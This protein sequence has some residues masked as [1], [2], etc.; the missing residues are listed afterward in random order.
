MAR[1][2]THRTPPVVLFSVA[3][4]AFIGIAVMVFMFSKKPVKAPIINTNTTTTN[5]TFTTNATT[6]MTITTQHTSTYVS[7]VP[8]SGVT[9]Q[10][11]PINVA[12]V[13]SS[14]LGPT[15]TISVTDALGT[16]INLGRA[17]FSDDRMTMTS[18]LVT[19]SSGVVRAS[20]TS[21][22]VDNTQCEEGSFGFYVTP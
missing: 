15:S 1:R 13:F 19:G 14:P 8:E 10:T 2:A 12:I 4:V 11:L 20:Y 3:V 21:C 17:R 6:P 7:S 18:D 16:P 22:A 5:R 9:L